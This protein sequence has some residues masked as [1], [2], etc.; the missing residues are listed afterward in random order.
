MH[1]NMSKPLNQKG[2][3]H[4][5]CPFYAECLTYAVNQGWDHWRC[6]KCD[7][8]V[9]SPVYERLHFIEEYYPLLA[10]IYPEFR[11][12]YERFMESYK[13]TGAAGMGARNTR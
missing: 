9:L 7:N 8:H 13:S 10:Q 1:R 5:D 11:S 12:K 4:V 6:G 2:A 3:K